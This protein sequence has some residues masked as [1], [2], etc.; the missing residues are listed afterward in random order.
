MKE[1]SRLERYFGVLPPAAPVRDDVW[2]GYPAAFI[3]AKAGASA[4]EGP[5]RECLDGLFGMVP[6]W[7]SDTKLSRS[8]YNARSE[9]V[10]EKPVF[11][12]AWR[13]AQH[14]IVPAETIFE[15]DWRSGKAVPSG[16]RLASGEPMGIAGLWAQW[17]SP[18]GD[19]MHSFTMLTVNADEHALM[20]QFHKPAD[21]KR[22]VVVLPQDQWDAWLTA[23]AANSANFL[24]PLA[25]AQLAAQA[26]VS[27]LRGTNLSLLD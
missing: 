11:R 22:M 17:R 3:R 12:D 2:P 6:H 4:P 16:I 8:T 14:C 15:P 23:T 13:R 5:I 24:Q 1:A 9:T 27:P 19:V 21:E 20:R 10:A 18:K 7:A 25:A 26:A